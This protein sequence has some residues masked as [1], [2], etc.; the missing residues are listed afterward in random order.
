MKRYIGCDV[1]ATSCTF[2]VVSESGR[3]LR[4]DVVETSGRALIDYVRCIPR[5]RHLVIEEG[6][7]SQWL[8]EVF[9]PH[10]DTMT[11]I[12]PENRRGS[13]DD[14]RDAFEVAEI[15][16]TGQVL[17]SMFAPR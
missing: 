13:K 17:L 12:Q 1:H 7:Q 14:T 10:V 15:L 9:T 6:E 8:V 4:R 16:R 5:E 3:R 11:V 2:A